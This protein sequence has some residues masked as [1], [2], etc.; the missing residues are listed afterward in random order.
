M[1]F[2]DPADVDRVRRFWNAPRMAT[3]P[4]LKAV[5]LFDAMLDGRV[6][7]LW[8]LGTNPAVSMSRAERVRAALA[9]CPF[10]AVSDCWPTDT[11]RFAE[12]VLPAAGWSEKDGTVTNSERCIS[13]QRAFRAPPG[14]ARQDWWTLSEVARRM[15][16]QA[17]LAYR[18]PADIFREH[19]GLSAFENEHPAR[20]IFDIGALSDLSD[21]DYERLPPVR[22]P[23][24]RGT[25]APWSSAKRLFGDGRGFA[26]S[27]GRALSCPRRTDRLR[28]PRTINGRSC[29]IPDACATNGTR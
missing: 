10:V 13:R 14:E 2:A 1:N 24:P 11:T 18:C 28:C 25:S 3:R 21:D 9:A 22:W 19:A 15:G 27:D 17:A 12:V 23:L 16:W 29:S 26:T 6:K 4:G 7:A 20:R 8:V 5:E